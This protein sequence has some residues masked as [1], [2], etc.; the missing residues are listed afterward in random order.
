MDAVNE[1]CQESIATEG[2]SFPRI[3]RNYKGENP[4]YLM[5]FTFRSRKSTQP[6]TYRVRRKNRPDSM[7]RSGVKGRVTR[8]SL[9][10]VQ[11]GDECG[12]DNTD[13]AAEG[14]FVVVLVLFILWKCR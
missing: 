2:Y 14:R 10:S 11:E 8:T 4:Q 9:S 13:S 12:V 1:N 3:K 5:T 6:E 7:G